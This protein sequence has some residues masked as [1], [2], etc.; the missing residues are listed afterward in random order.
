MSHDLDRAHLVD[1]LSVHD[2]GPTR[3]QNLTILWFLSSAIPEK[4]KGCKIL[5]WITWPGLRPFQGWS[6]VPGL[7]LDIACKHTKFDDEIGGP[8]T[9]FFAFFILCIFQPFQRYFRG[10]EILEC[11]T[12]P[13]PHP[14]RGHG[15]LKVLL[16][17]KPC[18]IFEVCSFNRFEDILWGVK[19]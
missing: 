19:F 15:H 7:T 4:F 18:T 9:T 11:V 13:W 1:S 5:K 14:L 3:A 8:K 12:W 10:C 6:V 16:V 17:A 2:F